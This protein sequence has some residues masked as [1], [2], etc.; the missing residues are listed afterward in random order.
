MI[1][2][3]RVGVHHVAA[4]AFCAGAFGQALEVMLPVKVKPSYMMVDIVPYEGDTEPI[5]AFLLPCV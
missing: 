4:V 3:A 5:R 2:C 1:T